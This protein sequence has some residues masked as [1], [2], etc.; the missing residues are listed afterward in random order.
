MKNLITILSIIILCVGQTLA[1]NDL[2]DEIATSLRSGDARSVS[3]YFGNTIDRLVIIGFVCI[4]F[5]TFDLFTAI[6]HDKR[7][8][9][10]K[11]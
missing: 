6:I 7:D 3:R 2:L 5:K 8:T 11:S 4:F 10:R 1:Q 9:N